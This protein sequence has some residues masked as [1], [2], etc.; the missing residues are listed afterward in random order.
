[1]SGV[2]RGTTDDVVLMNGRLTV[3]VESFPPGGCSPLL[4]GPG[5]F[6]SVG[7]GPCMGIDGGIPGVEDGSVKEY[8]TDGTVKL[9]TT[10][11]GVASELLKIPEL[12]I[13]LDGGVKEYMTID[14]RVEVVSPF[15]NLLGSLLGMEVSGLEDVLSSLPVMG[16]SIL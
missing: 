1:M 14:G 9:E 7:D 16:T 10:T 13:E 6:V 8:I 4:V 11:D 2:Q 15:S 12:G 5:L 3:E